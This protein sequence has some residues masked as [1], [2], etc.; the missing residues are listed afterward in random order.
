MSD[1]IRVNLEACKN[2]ESRVRREKT[3]QRITV[4][5]LVAIIR[6][7]VYSSFYS[8]YFLLNKYFIPENTFMHLP[9]PVTRLLS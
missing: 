6:C 4:A 8:N 3:L 9:I 2:V 7:L 5:L 1:L